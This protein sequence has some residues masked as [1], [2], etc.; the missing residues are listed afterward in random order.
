M[1]RNQSSENKSIK[2]EIDKDEDKE[3]LKQKID[4]Y[5][6]VIIENYPGKME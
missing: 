5:L 6:D 1:K 4:E 3:K 2:I